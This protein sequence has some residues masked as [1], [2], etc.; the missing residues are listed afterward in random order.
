MYTYQLKTHVYIDATI[1]FYDVE[2]HTVVNLS[3]ASMQSFD[4]EHMVRYE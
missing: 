2:Y 4:K 1:S 3:G